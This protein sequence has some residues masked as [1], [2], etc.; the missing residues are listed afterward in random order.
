MIANNQYNGLKCQ[1]K[2]SY[3]PNLPFY[4]Y[5]KMHEASVLTCCKRV[6]HGCGH[7]PQGTRKPHLFL[8][9][10]WPFSTLRI[11]L[12]E[13]IERGNSFT[14]PDRFIPRFLG[15]FSQPI[16]IVI[17]SPL[18]SMETRHGTPGGPSTAVAVVPTWVPNMGFEKPSCLPSSLVLGTFCLQLGKTFPTVPNL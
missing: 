9:L 11:G 13:T 2:K 10:I 12:V 4:V 17:S 18:F 5:L 7:P 6:A 16:K 14:L 8:P 3:L 15:N 1:K